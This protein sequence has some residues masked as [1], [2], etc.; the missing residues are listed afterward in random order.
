MT[1]ALPPLGG[2]SEPRARGQRGILAAIAAI[3]IFGVSAG[4]NHPL[5]A[6]R[7]EAQGYSAAMI[8]LN[9][10]MIA[11]AA[12]VAAPFMPPV[13]RWIGLPAFLTLG[14]LMAAATLLT[15]PFF[16]GYGAWLGLRF[17]LG[18]AATA[19]FLGSEAWI[20]A[21][22]EPGARGRIIGLYAT[23][24]SLGFAAGPMI[25]IGVGVE[26]PAPFIVCAALALVS[27]GPVVSAWRDAPAPEP[28]DVAATPPL[29]F[30]VIAPTVF[31]AV[32]LFGA[33]E[34][35]VMA[36]LPVWG[37]RTGLDRDAASFLVSILLLGNVALQI[38]LGALAEV[39]NRRVLLVGCALVSLAASAALP[40]LA[41]ETWRLWAMLFVWGGLAAGL[42]T[43]AL[44]E[45]GARYSGA[46]LV[47][48]TAAVVTAYG[49]G[50]LAGPLVTGAAMDLL[51]P[52]G[53]ALAL[54]LMALAYLSI[55][56]L[57][58]RPR[59]A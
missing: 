54:G 25:L 35:G 31:G 41:G 33:I 46:T 43:I 21:A 10:A 45:L 7:L 56:I 2:P 12:L 50:A 3:A 47:S 58:A 26:G 30:I 28:G 34:F 53:L 19:L 24:L 9:G 44:I 22:A 16:D 4:M 13:I 20:V 37:V 8:G 18:V 48:G 5:F 17:L 51:D 42:Y 27:I 52:H 40:F 29:R 15:F 6:L 32:I 59:K 49:I 57:R 11:I 39:V 38:P 23:V 55:A 1:Q 36:M 14:A